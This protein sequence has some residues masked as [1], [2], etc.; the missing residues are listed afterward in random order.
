[1][2][3]SL[4]VQLNI[5]PGRVFLAD[6]VTRSVIDR[7]LKGYK[8]LSIE[9]TTDIMREVAELTGADMNFDI[10]TVGDWLMVTMVGEGGILFR[11]GFKVSFQYPSGRVC[12]EE[13]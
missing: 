6:H 3:K 10:A 12:G 5:L 13:G 4:K 11:V 9:D 7:S 1:M 2:A 8:K